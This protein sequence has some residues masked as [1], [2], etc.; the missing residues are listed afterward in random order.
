MS[1]RPRSFK[2]D[3]QL[4]YQLDQTTDF[5]FQIHALEGE[6]Q[7][8]LSESLKLTPSAF[9]K[10]Y[11]DPQA[12]QRFLRVQAKR[13]KFSLRYQAQVDVMRPRLNRQ[14]VEHQ[15][16]DLPDNVLHNLMPTRYCES[17]LLASAA[18]KLFGQLPHGASRVEAICEWIQRNIDYRVG[19]SDSTTTACDVFLHH[20]GVCRDFAHLGVTLCRA[21]NIPARLAVG[22]AMFDTPPP[23]FHAMFEAYVGGRWELFDPT[24][25]SDPRELVLIATG[26]DA[27]DVAFA[28]IFGTAKTLA[29][30]PEV[31][32]A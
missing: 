9:Y 5:I 1:P 11:E 23:D 3:C 30:L 32:R 28:T 7:H 27:K 13:G 29:I 25:M 19:S 17:D 31:T 15:I 18:L 22:Y 6:N 8:I 20:A 14:A 12:G 21:L 24:R 26:R 16:A 4:S 2:V 10:V